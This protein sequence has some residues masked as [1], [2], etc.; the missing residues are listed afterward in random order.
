METG[1]EGARKPGVPQRT[2]WA[3]AIG[4]AITVANLYYSQPLLATMARSL[5][6]PEDQ[7]GIVSALTQSG[8]AAGL[9][10]LV[11][12]GDALERRR[13]LLTMLGIVTTM[14][15]A[16]A[17]S[18]G[19]V[20]LAI[21]S[22]LLGAATV[23]PQMLVPFAAGL[24]GLAERG[25]VVG[26]VM[27]GL[28]IGLLAARTVSGFVSA[29]F[30]WR[31]VYGMAAGLTVLLAGV[32]AQILPVSYPAQQ[33]SYGQLLR[34][35]GRLLAAQPALRQSCLFGATAFGAFSVFWTTLAFHLARPPFEFGSA[36]VGLF[37]LAGIAGA[38]A[39]PL[40][41]RVADRRGPMP[42]IGIG[43]TL[44]LLS[45]GLF[46]GF[47]QHLLGLVAGVLLLDFGVQSAHISN[48]A[49][50]YSLPA[51][52]HNR[53]NSVYMVAFFVGGAAGSALGTYGWTR[54]GWDGVCT[55]GA[56]FALVGLIGYGWTLLRARRGDSAP[57][58]G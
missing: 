41:G 19:I 5:E 21:A 44:T 28:L 30:G 18:P 37:G 58:A 54:W 9:L 1:P 35:F 55:A 2:V 49:R 42:L 33:L 11:P 22:L 20:W 34:S 48:Q 27:S 45:F 4:C 16:V 10:L 25:W 56:G 6:V 24:A 31:V 57:D 12:L 14:L 13:L 39:A 7:L 15:V 36:A 50:I 47:G 46:Y 17:V 8:Y 38:L 52:M 53:L 43:L 26:R 40:A 51:E 32:Y 23:V 3:L 29:R